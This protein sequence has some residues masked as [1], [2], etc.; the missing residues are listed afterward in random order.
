MPNKYLKMV[1]LVKVIINI[2]IIKLLLRLLCYT[3]IITTNN[4]H[5]DIK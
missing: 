5:K 2:S 1:S 3:P 4:N